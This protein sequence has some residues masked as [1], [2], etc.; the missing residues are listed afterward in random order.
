LEK[1]DVKIFVR[2]RPSVLDPAGEAV[3]SASKNLGVNGLES[4]RIGKLIEVVISSDSEKDAI[5]KI[6]L[7]CDRLLSNQVIED[8]DYELHLNQTI[9]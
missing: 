4:I 5:S 8:Y 7:L 2:L 3:K 9:S 6:D 1:F